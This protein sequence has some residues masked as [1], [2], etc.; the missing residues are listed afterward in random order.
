MTSAEIDKAKLS[1][2]LYGEVFI[3]AAGR[4]LDPRC[5]E[6]VVED[7]A[8]TYFVKDPTRYFSS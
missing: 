3:D 5:V 7:G 6:V 4:V 1:A 2:V 8:F